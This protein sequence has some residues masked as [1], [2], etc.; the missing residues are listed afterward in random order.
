ML[1]FDSFEKDFGTSNF[2][3]LNDIAFEEFEYFLN[4]QI[5]QNHQVKI[6]N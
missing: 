2:Q 6:H 1:A 3:L 4:I 5:R